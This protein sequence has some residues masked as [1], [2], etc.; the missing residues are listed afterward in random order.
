VCRE[1]QVK[2]EMLGLCVM[3]QTGNKK[4]LG[5]VSFITL[6]RRNTFI[7]PENIRGRDEFYKDG[8]WDLLLCILRDTFKSL[9]ETLCLQHDVVHIPQ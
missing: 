1:L 9:R 8:L 6:E 7:C 4:T 3:I 5:C 2:Q